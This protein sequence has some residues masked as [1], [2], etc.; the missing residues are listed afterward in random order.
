MNIEKIN[1]VDVNFLVSY[2]EKIYLNV[3]DYVPTVLLAVI[4]FFVGK[5]VIK[6]VNKAI[7]LFFRKA[8]FDEALE[9]FAQSLISISLKIILAII[10][11]VILGVETSSFVAVFGAMVFAVGMAL[12]GS[13]SN[14]AGGV[15]ILFFKPFKIGD[16]ITS[17]SHSGTVV[18]IQIFNT[19]LKTPEG[20]KIILP[21][22]PVSNDTITNSTDIKKRRAEFLIGVSYND[23]I[24]K[25][26]E[27][28][29]KI[30]Q[31]EERILKDEDILV[32]VKNLGDNAVEILFRF[33]TNK[34]D[35]WDTKYDV[36]ETVKERFDE[37]GISFPFPQRDVHIFNEK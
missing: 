10:V 18:D 3:W 21:N 34:D 13:L 27:V 7:E 20:V 19:I 8:D 25:V 30:A 29:N 32:G 2:L 6:Y 28:L 33:W 4:V 36:L 12:Q 35:F 17:G 26:K 23:N 15:L 31:D 16:Y 1:D 22:G 24:K 11:V 9:R 5:H 14:F 37:E